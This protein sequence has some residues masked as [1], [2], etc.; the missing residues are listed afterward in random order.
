[1][2]QTDIDKLE[3]RFRELEDKWSESEWQD[4]DFLRERALEFEDT[5]VELAYRIMQRAHNL[6]PNGGLI[7]NKLQ[8][9]RQL[10]LEQGS[11]ILMSSSQPAESAPAASIATDTALPAPKTAIERL[12]FWCQQPVTLL[13]V[14]PWLLLAIYFTILA[15][16]R[17]ESHA[18]VIVRKP[19]I[20]HGQEPS[21]ALLGGRTA[22]AA[23]DTQLIRAFIH[24]RDM[25]VHLQTE[26]ALFE[27]YTA[28]ERDVFSR[29]GKDASNDEFLAFYEK[30]I[31]VDVD[32]ASS[33]VTIK[34]QAFSGEYAQQL[35]Q[36]IIAKSEDYIN[37]IGQSLARK[38]LTF[39]EAEHR[40]IEERLRKAKTDQ[41]RFQQKYRLFDP[42]QEAQA[43]QQIA[44]NLE[45]VLSDKKT[46]L[47]ALQEYMQ[48]S[49]P[50]I[51]SLQREITALEKQLVSEKQRLISQKGQ[52]QDISFG[53]V[54][55]RYSA[56]QIKVDLAMQA[57]TS[58]L[59]SLERSRI[60]AY[61]QLQYMV[62]VES[63][64]LPEDH[65][66]P[67]KLYNLSLAAVV[68]M[69]L[70]GIGKILIATIKELA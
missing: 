14:V 26:L 65:S 69:I 63:P 20:Q 22:S 61:R 32:E 9:Y 37:S 12:I 49:S 54:L 55:A 59:V 18:Q 45:E 23:G 38:R 66:Y 16:P 13:V 64:T 2:S 31:V 70:F 17:Y 44:F 19:D 8:E 51:R 29:L 15:S 27:H 28:R 42:Q 62:V 4:A 67:D 47:L 48:E 39:I 53:E 50:K 24:S 7:K 56:F 33:V 41:L 52:Q 35:N 43:V 1:M 30:H 10:L 60:E 40:L 58:S 21:S 11:P 3:Q 36:Q 57:Y 25:L 46:Q 6:R 68:L 34:T 5:D